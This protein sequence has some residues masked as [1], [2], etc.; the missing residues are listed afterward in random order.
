MDWEKAALLV[1]GAAVATLFGF[2]KE[3][4]TSRKKNEHDLSFLVVTIA[5]MLDQ[6][7]AECVEVCEDD[8][9]YLGQVGPEGRKRRAPDPKFDPTR[10]NVN[11]D[12]LKPHLLNDVLS[13]PHLVH[14]ATRK[15]L[16][17]SEYSHPPDYEE[18]F[19]TWHHSFAILGLTAMR[20]ASVLREKAK[21]ERLNLDSK[22]NA[23][24]FLEHTR[25]TVEAQRKSRQ[26]QM[27]KVMAAGVIASTD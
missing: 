21:I 6:F 2:L 27:E 13:L 17:V 11:W 22:F 26:K 19:E 10:A 7:V 1:V 12:V 20:L 4:L 9:S 16:R 3:Y 8:G 24:E 15:V 25:D 5:C 18:E 23:R 14:N